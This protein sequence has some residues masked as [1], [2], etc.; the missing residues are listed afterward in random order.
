M[1]YAA[2][3]SQHFND[4]KGYGWDIKDVNFDWQQM[5]VARNKE[6][7]RLEAAYKKNLK[8][9]GVKFMKVLQNLRG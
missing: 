7:D 9:S 1:V 3:F 4:S 6:V 2:E 5:V 8:N